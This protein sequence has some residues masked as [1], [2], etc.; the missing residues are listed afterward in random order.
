M[1]CEKKRHLR[2]EDLLASTERAELDVDRFEK[3]LAEHV[4]ASR[5]HEDFMSGVRSGVNR[6]P[7]FH[8]NGVRHDDSYDADTMLEALG[9]ASS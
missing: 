3:E 8:I 1:L 5:V 4:H 7:T 9:G 2:D 6:T